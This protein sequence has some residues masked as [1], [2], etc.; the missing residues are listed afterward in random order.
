LARDDRTAPDFEQAV[1]ELETL[2]KRLEQSELSL[3]EQLATFERG[4]ALT[5]HCQAL[6]K[7]AQQK[8]EILTK[9]GAQT[10]VEPFSV[11]EDASLERVT[12]A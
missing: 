7:A 5:R 1:A 12:E 11:A 6:L 8:V 3:D 2:V 10:E 4:V 9:R